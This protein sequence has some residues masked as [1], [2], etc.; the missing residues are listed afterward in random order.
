MEI[1]KRQNHFGWYFVKSY[2]YR[3]L[4]I[5][6]ICVYI[7]MH[8]CCY[9]LNMESKKKERKKKWKD[10]EERNLSKLVRR[11]PKKSVNTIWFNGI[12]SLDAPSRLTTSHSDI[13]TKTKRNEKKKK[14]IPLQNMKSSA[15]EGD[16]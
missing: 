9:T 2:I 16:F 5:F 12:Y 15:F 14:K 11:E 10:E 6:D 13:T 7:Y 1:S 3:A 4:H 8:G